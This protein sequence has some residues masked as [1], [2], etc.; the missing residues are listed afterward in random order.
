MNWTIRF[1]FRKGPEVQF[2][3]HL[4]LVRT[5]ERALRRADLPM[6]YSGG[7]TARPIMS[8]GYALPVGVSSEAEYGDFEFTKNLD[9][10]EFMTLYNAHLP[11]GFE[12]LDAQCLPVGSPSLM[13]E[14]NAA[15]WRICLPSTSV[16]QMDERL[17]WLQNVDS[18]IVRRQTK[19]GI[20]E[21]DVRSFLFAVTGVMSSSDGTVV[22]CLCG[23][24]NES[25]LRMEELGEL[26]GFSHLE[27]TITRMGQFKRVGDQYFPPLGN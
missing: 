24:G 1:R 17:Q 22:D 18:F 27:A 12:V 15:S 9:P 7:F 16:S 13:N 20:R 23:L 14:I 5:M 8:Y 3:S 21:L 26:L 19:R 11:E 6:A 2:L 10:L 4:D 25:N